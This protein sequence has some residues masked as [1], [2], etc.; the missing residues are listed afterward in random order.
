MAGRIEGQPEQIEEALA[1]L[2]ASPWRPPAPD[3]DVLAVGGMGGSAIAAE[4][5]GALHADRLPRPL[6]VV[7]DYR[8]PACVGPRALA[9]LSSY[10]GNTEETLA[11]ERA[12]RERGVPRAAI[13]SG[14]E[15]AARA[16]ADGVPVALVPGGSPP[17][18]AL[19]SGWV[20]LEGLLHALG[21]IPDPR[22]AWREAAALLRSRNARFV[23]GAGE[24]GNPAKRLARSLH[25]RFPVIYSAAERV[26]AV[27]TRWRQQLHE[28]AKLPGHSAAVP[29]L[30][31]NEIVG[32]ERPGEPHRALS[33][34]VLRDR[35]D[36]AESARRLS[37]TAD[38]VRAQGAP[39]HEC[40]S[41]GESRQARMASLVQL[42]D[43]V[44]F[45]LAMLA[46]VDP[47]PIASIDAFKRRLSERGGPHGA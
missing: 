30:N 45:Y 47:T 16:R 2:E 38:Y 13:T 32:W 5:A 8:W 12:A 29:E 34:V 10:S 21:W 19:F 46:E 44:S 20:A 15:L 23:P 40:E 39:A 3:P 6:L 36:A 9:V 18:A 28:N 7:R 37:L 22:P 42:G 41:E 31:H 35:E 11:L 14:G 25:G 26:G 27:A 1:R 4:L 17:R 24:E 33:V 43:W